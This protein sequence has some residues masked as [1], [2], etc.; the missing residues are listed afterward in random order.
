[1]AFVAN[2]SEIGLIDIGTSVQV[3][4]NPRAKLMF[5]LKSMCSVLDIDD[6]NIS[7]L[8][9]YRNY[10]FLTD[11]E[12]AQLLL[13]C[14]ALSP[15]ELNGKCIFQDEDGEMCGDSVNAFYELSA[16]QHRVYVT[17]NILIGNQQR[18]VKK[19][20]FYRMSFIQDYYLVPMIV[21]KVRLDAIL[22]TQRTARP[23]ITYNQ[24][25]RSV[26]TPSHSSELT[27]RPS[28]Y[29][30]YVYKTSV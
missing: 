7:R 15:D 25:T 29:R 13:L 16:V 5:Y 9:D 1:M 4:D 2:R 22:E 26:A 8:I 20:M 12:E 30:Y 11:A 6:P 23:A 17:E 19:M 27:Y 3:P 14:Y 21:L 18:H 10:Y 28:N 24:P